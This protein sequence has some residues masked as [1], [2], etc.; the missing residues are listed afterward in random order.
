MGFGL[1]GHGTG[2]DSWQ[3]QEI[4][5]LNKIQTGFEAHSTSYPMG[6]EKYFHGFK[7]ASE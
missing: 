6:S 1:D 2:F 4:S 7:T 5:L 3:G